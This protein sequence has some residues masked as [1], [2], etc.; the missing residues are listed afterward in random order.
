MIRTPLK[1]S[2]P[3]TRSPMSNDNLTQAPLGKQSDYVCEYEPSLLFPIARQ[4]KRDEINVPSLLPFYGYDTWNAFEVSW[5]N[6]KGK[7]H[8]AIAQFDIECTGGLHSS[9]AHPLARGLQEP[10]NAR[11]AQSA[12]NDHDPT[13][14]TVEL[15][16]VEYCAR[17]LYA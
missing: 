3:P 13:A 11:A 14:V 16:I 2:I 4:I 5:L 8:V 6:P 9:S 10:F 15:N 1:L 7:P 12:S 17:V